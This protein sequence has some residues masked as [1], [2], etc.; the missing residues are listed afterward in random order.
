MTID[1][2]PSRPSRT[3][4][5][6]VPL[7]ILMLALLAGDL[8]LAMWVV[9]DYLYTESELVFSLVAALG[10]YALLVLVALVAGFALPRLRTRATVGP[11]L[12]LL[13]GLLLFVLVTGEWIVWWR[14]AAWGAAFFMLGAALPPYI[15]LTVGLRRLGT[16]ISWLTLFLAIAIGSFVTVN[17]AIVFEVALPAAVA[18]IVLPVRE[19]VSD[20]LRARSLEEAFFS[21]G[22]I[23]A[24]IES[25]F[26]APIAEEFAK[27]LVV[28]ILMSRIHSRREAFLVGMAG[29]V[30]FAILE[31]MFYGGVFFGDR[32]LEVT[33]IR[34]MGAPL[35]PFGAGIVGLAIYDVW[36][37]RPR[38]PI[39]LAGAFA[40]AVGIHAAWNG[41]IVLLYASL[42]ERL[43]TD[44]VRFSR[45]D[46]QEPLAIVL[47]LFLLSLLIW[48]LLLVFTARLRADAGDQ[49][50]PLPTLS[51]DDPRRLAHIGTGALAAAVL[52][53][54]AAAPV[55][56]RLFG[57]VL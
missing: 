56:V 50:L 14:S 5:L 7:A 22:L 45:F 25:A 20:L 35:H 46:V 52:L 12:P 30:G 1:T 51:L 8:G 36:Q 18:S 57:Q 9:A 43:A 24:M 42:H 4:L 23:I 15:A 28:L 3:A 49:V 31:N 54:T 6:V 47:Y 40:L 37:R 13:I 11:P 41:G 33:A 38:G 53:G 21:R 48:W 44:T 39:R 10:V 55:L 27:P 29:G 34:S 16:S 19:L 26:V 2:H 17:V 32:W